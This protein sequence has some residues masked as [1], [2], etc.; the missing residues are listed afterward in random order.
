MSM[1][2]ATLFALISGAFALGAVRC[3]MRGDGAFAEV[4]LWGAIPFAI[5]TGCAFLA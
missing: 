4:N 5:L 2:L 1:I 3:W